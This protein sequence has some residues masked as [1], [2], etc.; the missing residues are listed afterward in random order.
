MGGVY[1]DENINFPIAFQEDS[2]YKIA[3]CLGI[4]TSWSLANYSCIIADK[5]ASGCVF[6]MFM[7]GSTNQ[8]LAC[9]YLIMG[10]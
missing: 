1:T 6:R 9:E 4:G 10:Y 2:T 5:T 7:N 3:V 8:Y